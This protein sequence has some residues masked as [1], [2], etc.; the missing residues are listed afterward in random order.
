MRSRVTW[1]QP[2]S[3]FTTKQTEKLVCFVFFFVFFLIWILWLYM[4]LLIEN[5][6]SL[7]RWKRENEVRNGGR[8]FLLGRG[9]YRQIVWATISIY[10]FFRGCVVVVVC[11]CFCIFS[12]PWE[13]GKLGKLPN[14]FAAAPPSSRLHNFQGSIIIISSGGG[15][16]LLIYYRRQK[17]SQVLAVLVSCLLLDGGTRNES[18]CSCP[19]NWNRLIHNDK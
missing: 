2:A 7:L 15:G 14:W 9:K 10:H 8:N 6:Q 19:I 13:N 12:D 16:L 18:C 1:P 4:E 5:Q 3:L 11:G 17:L